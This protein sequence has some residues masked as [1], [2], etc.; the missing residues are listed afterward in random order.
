MEFDISMTDELFFGAN[1]SPGIREMVFAG[2]SSHFNIS[3]A[4]VEVLGPMLGV[5]KSI[6]DQLLSARE[7]ENWGEMR[8]LINIDNWVFGGASP[9][10]PG[11][12]YVLTYGDDAA[13]IIRVQ[14]RLTPYGPALPY[15][16]VEW[17]APYFGHG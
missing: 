3:T 4:P 11:Y 15:Q 5:G 17:Q 8:R 10:A 16:I 12:R 1:G 14:V 7:R 2:G 6:E 9:F 13:G